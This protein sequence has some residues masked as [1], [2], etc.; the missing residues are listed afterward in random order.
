MTSGEVN[1][2]VGKSFKKS[3]GDTKLGTAYKTLV[4]HP[5]K[6]NGCGDC[7][8]ACAKEKTS[9]TDINHSRMKVIR[10]LKKEFFGPVVCLQ[11]GDPACVKSCPAGA[12]TKNPATVPSFHTPISKRPSKLTARLRGSINR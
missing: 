3:K 2:W 8:I 6:C 12:L 4:V 10:N 1:D 5:D 7:E 11:C 9:S